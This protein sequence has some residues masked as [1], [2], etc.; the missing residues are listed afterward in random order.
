MFF[1][2]INNAPVPVPVVS[3][4]LQDPAPVVSKPVPTSVPVVSDS[5]SVHESEL[6]VLYDQVYE[7]Y[8]SV[9][10]VSRDFLGSFVCPVFWTDYDYESD[11]EKYDL[12]FEPFE[13]VEEIEISRD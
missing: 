7:F 13:P 2:Q 11:L 1:R 8:Q 4:P 3:K 10:N 6:D 9:K 12:G 5:E